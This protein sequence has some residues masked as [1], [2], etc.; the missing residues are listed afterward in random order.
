LVTKRSS[1]TSCTLLAPSVL[2]EALPA[3]PVVLGAAVL[4]AE[5]RVAWQTSG[6]YSD[7][8]SAAEGLVLALEVVRPVLSKNSLLATSS[9]S[10]MS[11]RA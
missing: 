4:D 2:G 8:V 5:D 3:V 10:L 6:W 7:R 9:A 11:G 1:P